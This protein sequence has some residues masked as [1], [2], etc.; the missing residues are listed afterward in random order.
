METFKRISVQEAHELIVTQ[1]VT[2]VD[3]RDSKS[4]ELG[5]I[6]NAYRLNEVNID[7]FITKIDK[8]IPLICY[9]YHGISSQQAAHFL[10]SQGFKEVF[11]IDGGWEA[12]RDTY[13]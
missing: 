11:S 1:A 7:S 5:H 9:C 12:W 6:E 8:E 10:A 4:F 3:I 2:I 13:V